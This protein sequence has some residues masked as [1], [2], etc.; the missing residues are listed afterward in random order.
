MTTLPKKGVFVKKYSPEEL[1]VI[2]KMLI[3][4]ESLAIEM[5]VPNIS[6]E[7]LN[8][9]QKMNNQIT[10][11]PRLVFRSNFEAVGTQSSGFNADKPY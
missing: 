8:S 5:A 11:N 6:E 7:D 9:L 4:L 3:R 2:H 1:D 10:V